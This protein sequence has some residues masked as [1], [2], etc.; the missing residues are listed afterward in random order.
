V[1]S[2][3]ESVALEESL[4]AVY[5]YPDSW[6]IFFLS[7]T[8]ALF[9]A[10]IA[11]VC[12]FFDE[13]ESTSVLVNPMRGEQPLCIIPPV[14]EAPRAGFSEHIGVEL[15]RLDGDRRKIKLCGE[16]GEV[17][18]WVL[19][20]YPSPSSSPLHV[21]VEVVEL[22]CARVWVPPSLMGWQSE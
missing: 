20:P 21:E 2:A 6:Q 13:Y 7:D 5:T 19:L 17:S 12:A 1:F 18:H 10:V 14:F 22:D 3:R 8:P 4:F 15:D 11:R 9:F 16:G